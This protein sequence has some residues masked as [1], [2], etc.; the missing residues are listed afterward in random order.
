MVATFIYLIF[1]S[2]FVGLF[3]D[4]IKDFTKIGERT[5][6]RNNFLRRAKKHLKDNTCDPE[7]ID[8]L[9][10]DLRECEDYKEM[11]LCFMVWE[12]S[13]SYPYCK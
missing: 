13:H 4:A 12:E 2:W 3:V 7:E 11:K 9:E 10:Q 8:E 6:Y 5:T 1:L